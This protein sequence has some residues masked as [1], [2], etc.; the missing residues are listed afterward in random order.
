MLQTLFVRKTI[1]LVLYFHIS[2]W[3]G[4]QGRDECSCG[5]LDKCKGGPEYNCHCDLENG[6]ETDDGGWIH[7]KQYLAICE[8]CVGLD[9]L[10]NL[11][12]NVT[13]RRRKVQP[14][15]SDLI[16]DI[17]RIGD[18]QLFTYSLVNEKF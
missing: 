17:G 8:V 12:P 4:S 11:N 14:S 10:S 7:D 16:C 3:A 5:A 15:V 13:Q 6:E 2:G 9:K 1:W 18:S